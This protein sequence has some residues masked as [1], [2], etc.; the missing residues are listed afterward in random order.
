VGILNVDEEREMTAWFL[1]IVL[2]LSPDNPVNASV[3]FEE[4]ACRM[5]ASAINAVTNA[6][7]AFCRKGKHDFL[8]DE[9]KI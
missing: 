8:L 9:E 3:F 2:A 6:L 1:V 7:F 4:S 5:E